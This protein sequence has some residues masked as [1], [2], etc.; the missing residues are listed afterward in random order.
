M[1]KQILRAECWEPKFL[2]HAYNRYLKF[3]ALKKLDDRLFAVPV[4][5]MDLMWHIHMGMSTKYHE[6]CAVLLGYTMGHDD[7]VTER[8]GGGTQSRSVLYIISRCLNPWSLC[9]LSSLH[10][11]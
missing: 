1:D 6:D 2:R 9:S 5:D 8:A 11:T 3:L 4:Y 10:V 7:A